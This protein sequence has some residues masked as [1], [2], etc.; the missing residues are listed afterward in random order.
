MR[1][2]LIAL[3][4][5]GACDVGQVNAPGPGPGNNGGPDAPA[6][7]PDAAPAVGGP[8]ASPNAQACRNPVNTAA[9]GN[10][11]AGTDC[12]AGNC[13][14]PGGAGPTWTVAGTLYTSAAGT[15]PIVGGTITLTLAAGAPIDLVSAQNGNFWTADPVALPINTFASKCPAITPMIS[16]VAVGSCNSCHV[17]NSATGSIHLP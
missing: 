14:G 8:D 6:G 1:S 5:V 11:N 7:T 15:T 4:L 2:V 13:H 10:H 17:P 16:A 9:S 12:M 3:L